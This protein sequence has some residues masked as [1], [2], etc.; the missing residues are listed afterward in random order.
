MA[1]DA[2]AVRTHTV[3]VPTAQ[4]SD[5]TDA[6][7]KL[8]IP[9]HDPGIPFHEPENHSSAPQVV[10]AA[11]HSPYPSA[12]SFALAVAGYVAAAVADGPGADSAAVDFG[13]PCFPPDRQSGAS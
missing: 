2:V 5:A 9:V 6:V 13:L 8:H 3:P 11:F 1:I 12:A 10:D 7:A 4:A